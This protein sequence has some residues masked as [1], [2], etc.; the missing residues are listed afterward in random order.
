MKAIINIQ[1]SSVYS[2]FNFLTFDISEIGSSF[3]SIKGLN[4]EFPQNQTDFNF[5]EVI[6][7]DVEK[8]MEKC[9]IECD[10]EKLQK[11]EKYCDKKGIQF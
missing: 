1:T 8:E 6:I 4:P 7:V 3:V 10:F 11:L 9:S 2:K 5:S